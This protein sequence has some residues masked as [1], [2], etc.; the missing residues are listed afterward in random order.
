MFL[1]CSTCAVN[2]VC[3][4]RQLPATTN[5]CKTRGCNY[6]FELLM[7]SGVSLETCWAIKK[8]WNNK[9]YYTVASHWLFLWDLYYDTRIHEHQVIRL[10][11]SVHKYESYRHIFMKFRTM[12]LTSL[13]IL[14]VLRYIKEYQG[15]LKQNFG[16]RGHNT[17]YELNLHTCYCSTILYLGS[18]KNT[19]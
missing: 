3:S 13:Y 9:F 6:S 5:V 7:M 12:T 1:N 15:N 14:E 11:T 19:G 4:W 18:V 10:I 2:Y 17:R 8:H 16:I